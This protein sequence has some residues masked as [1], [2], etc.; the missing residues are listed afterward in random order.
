MFEASAG[1]WWV[2]HTRSRHEKAVASTLG[3]QCICYYL[4]LVRTQRTYG[5]RHVTVRMP[6]FPSYL[7]LCGGVHECDAAWRTKRV[8]RILHAENQEQL[9]TELRDI[10]RVVESG[11][12]VD[13]YPSLREG[14][15]CRVRSGPLRGVEGVVIRR[16]T[17]CRMYI[18]ATMLGQSAVIEID[19]AVLEAVD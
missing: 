16:R 17:P 7:F 8:A 4:P 9:R 18:A 1:R 3:K 13:L 10:Y 6:L 2:L 15:R 14:R 5:R 11:Q 12:P 19:A